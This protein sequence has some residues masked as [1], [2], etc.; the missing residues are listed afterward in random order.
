MSNQKTK[1]EL[2][3]AVHTL[4]VALCVGQKGADTCF[5]GSVVALVTFDFGAGTFVYFFGATGTIHF[6]YRL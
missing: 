6:I 5:A 3:V 4:G 1:V 2:G